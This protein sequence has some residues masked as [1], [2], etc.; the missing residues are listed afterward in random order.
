MTESEGIVPTSIAEVLRAEFGSDKAQDERDGRL[1]V[2]EVL[3]GG[4]EHGVQAPEAQNGEHVRREDDDGV[5]GHAE[6]CRHRVDREYDVGYLDAD[7]GQE[8]GRGHLPAVWELGEEVDPVV[9]V[10]RLDPPRGEFDHGVL[11]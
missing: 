8:E 3:H 7:E 4:G 1:Q 6:D 10:R 2:L 5:L 9:L 11:P